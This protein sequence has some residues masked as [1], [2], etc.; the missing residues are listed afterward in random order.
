MIELKNFS[1]TY[2]RTAQTAL[3]HISLPVEKGRCVLVTGPSGA[4]KTTLC[5]A[6]AGI[7]FHEYGGKKEGLV[8]VDGRDVSSFATLSEVAKTI[9]I[10]FDDAE[11]QLI[12]TTVKEEIL[13]ALEY[14]GLEEKVIDERFDSIVAT[15]YLTEL[16]NRSP[17][18][19]SGGQKQR[20]ALAHTGRAYCRT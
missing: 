15:T 13:S 16:L 7:L 4:G 12:F 14:R 2:P 6:A 20:V 17:H 19:L 18:H 5:L 1:Y 9:G 3:D 11:A 10:V 8:T